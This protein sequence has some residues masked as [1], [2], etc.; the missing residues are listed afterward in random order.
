MRRMWNWFGI[1]CLAF[2]MT[3]AVEAKSRPKKA[4]T[5][6]V[7]PAPAPGGVNK[8]DP[9]MPPP[10]P[11][12]KGKVDAP[13]AKAETVKAAAVL[14]LRFASPGKRAV[15]AC[16]RRVRGET[17]FREN[18][19]VETRRS[20]KPA[21]AEMTD[22]GKTASF[23]G[24]PPDVYDLVVVDLDARV[25]YEGI[26]LLADENRDLANGSVGAEIRQ[27]VTRN[28]AKTARRRC[29]RVATDGLRGAALVQQTW[30]AKAAGEEAKASA[31][32]LQF[33][34]AVWLSKVAEEGGW[35]VT[36][37]QRLYWS[38]GAES[39]LYKCRHR[40]ELQGIRLGSDPKDVGVVLAADITEK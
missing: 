25:M 22:G 11:G 31:A 28:A 27:A 19:D 17:L 13:A 24:L 9:T 1:A 15:I 16:G 14:T 26:D 3:A 40:P 35:Q 29:E 37:R 20:L 4:A 18:A 6:L 12:G 34:D 2:G 33:L 23:F 5:P 7:A 38:E 30:L 39:G 32:G 21:R 8:D 10:L 36:G